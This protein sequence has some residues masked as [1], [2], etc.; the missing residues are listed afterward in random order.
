[1]HS[2]EKRIVDVKNSSLWGIGF[3]DYINVAFFLSFLDYVIN[4]LFSFL[5]QLPPSYLAKRLK[6]IVPG[7]PDG[8]FSN[9]KSHF[10]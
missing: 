8:S 7:L 3:I 6:I 5:V 1:M 2:F 10:G 4:K 9:Q